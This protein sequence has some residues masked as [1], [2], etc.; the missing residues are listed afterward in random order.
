MKRTLNNSSGSMTIKIMLGIIILI[1]VVIAGLIVQPRMRMAKDAKSL[2][3]VA[4]AQTLVMKIST[5]LKLYKLDNGVYPTTEQG[6][7]ALI[8]KPTVGMIPKSYKGDGYFVMKEIPKDPWGNA[9]VYDC[10]GSN[11]DFDLSSY[12]ADGVKG[13]EGMNADIISR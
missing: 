9:F 3:A 13:G 10:P 1:L 5:A 8:K 6:L 7:N 2:Q 12:G 4:D 11:G